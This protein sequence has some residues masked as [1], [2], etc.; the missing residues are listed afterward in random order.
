MLR[1]TCCG[2]VSPA[3]LPPCALCIELALVTIE[4]LRSCFPARNMEPSEGTVGGDTTI[5]GGAG[6]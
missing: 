5:M 4:S 2:P 3:S 6:G 1:A